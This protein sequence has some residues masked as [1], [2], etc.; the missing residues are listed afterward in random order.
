M[1]SGTSA[2]TVGLLGVGL[3]RP[4]HSKVSLEA[5]ALTGCDAVEGPIMAFLPTVGARAGIEWRP[6]F[7]A[8]QQ[9]TASVT[10]IWDLSSRH[11]Y[12][13]EV[14]GTTLYGTIATGFA[15]P[16]K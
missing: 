15:F 11:A 8:F 5:V 6:R 1:M 4:V 14:G 10:G 2:R 9:V 7:H 3:S 13:R 16:P 12:G